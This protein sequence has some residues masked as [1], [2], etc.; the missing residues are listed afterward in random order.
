[1]PSPLEYELMY[2]RLGIPTIALEP[3][4]KVPHRQ[5]YG[6]FVGFDWLVAALD[7]AAWHG[8]RCGPGDALQALHGQGPAVGDLEGLE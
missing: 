3:L 5:Y 7:H 8:G 1:V 6:Q 4:S 2:A